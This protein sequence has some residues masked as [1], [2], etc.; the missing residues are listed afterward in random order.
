MADDR[1]GH[2][3][4]VRQA[5]IDAATAGGLEAAPA[6]LAQAWGLYVDAGIACAPLQ[7]RDRDGRVNCTGLPGSG[8]RPTL[9]MARCAA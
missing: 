1:T 4:A 7:G 6:D 8:T 9:V 5:T 2:F 3:F